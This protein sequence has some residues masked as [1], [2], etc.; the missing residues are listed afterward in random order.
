MFMVDISNRTSFYALERKYATV[1]YSIEVFLQLTSY[2][3]WLL[4]LM[5]NSDN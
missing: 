3:G 1:V 2:Y 5:T 4:W